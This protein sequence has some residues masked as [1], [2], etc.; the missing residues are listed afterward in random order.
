M[1]VRTVEEI[2]TRYTMLTRRYRHDDSDEA[3][4]HVAEIIEAYD[5]LTG[6]KVEREKVDPKDL[7]V[8]FGRERREWRNLIDYGWKPF[9]AGAIIIAVIVSIIYSAV[10]NEQPDYK[11]TYLG[12]FGDVRERFDEGWEDILKE[13]GF[14][15]TPFVRD[16]LCL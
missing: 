5:L 13:N 15:E 12:A 6:K 7:E 16:S 1:K 4:V 10:T 8:V 11:I 14:A 3:S 2:E 9:V